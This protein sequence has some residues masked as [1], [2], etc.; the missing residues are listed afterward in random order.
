MSEERATPMDYMK[1]GAPVAMCF[2]NS[3]IVQRPDGSWTHTKK[4]GIVHHPQMG[5]VKPK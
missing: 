2:C 5:P 4:H 3:R 1:Q